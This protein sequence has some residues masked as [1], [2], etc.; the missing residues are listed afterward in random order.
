MFAY[1]VKAGDTLWKIARRFHVSMDNLVELNNLRNP[2]KLKVGAELRIPD[3]TTDARDAAAAP[4]AGPPPPSMST[5]AIDRSRFVLSPTEYY[6]VSMPKDLIVLHFTAGADAASAFR[7]WRSNPEHVATAYIVDTDGTIY[8]LFDPSCWAYHLGVKGTKGL[9]DKRSVGIEIAN[10]GP[11]KP[12]P[13]TPTSLNWWPPADRW[14]TAWCQT[15]EADQYLK[16]PYRGINM[17]RRIS[18]PPA[19]Y[20]RAAGGVCV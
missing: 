10:V 2:D 16:V 18:R 15:A 11:L 6:P 13:T 8:E 7:T 12:S 17:L 3:L 20:R 9:H 4:I 19:R 5:L 1:K 14:E